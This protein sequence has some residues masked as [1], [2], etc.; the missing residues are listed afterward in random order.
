MRWWDDLWLNEGFASFV[1]YLGVAAV[2]PDWAMVS[3]GSNNRWC[4]EQF[5][6]T[7]Y[8]DSFRSR[9]LNI[10]HQHQQSHN[11]FCVTVKR[12]RHRRGCDVI[13]FLSPQ[14]WTQQTLLRHSAAWPITFSEGE[15][16]G[17][18][19]G[20]S[21]VIHELSHTP[22]THPPVTHCQTSQSRRVINLTTF[23]F[24]F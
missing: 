18:L 2:E 7:Y 22:F 8:Q 23:L 6:S 13:R 12:L 9:C 16:Q 24:M 19:I 4:T 11:S 5:S 10:S 1:E 14:W 3:N 21:N 15:N 20:S 17:S